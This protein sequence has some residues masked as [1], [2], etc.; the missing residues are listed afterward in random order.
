MW[1][2]FIVPPFAL[3]TD[4]FKQAPAKNLIFLFHSLFLNVFLVYELKL[5]Q[6]QN[7]TLLW[8]SLRSNPCVLHSHWAGPV[9]VLIASGA[10]QMASKSLKSLWILLFKPMF[11]IMAGPAEMCPALQSSPWLLS[12]NSQILCW[13]DYQLLPLNTN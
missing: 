12:V 3:L 11:L 10:A 2:C 6:T 9:W 13:I 7:S 1:L 5:F 4:Y 8:E